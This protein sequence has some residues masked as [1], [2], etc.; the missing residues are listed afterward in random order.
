MATAVRFEG[1]EESAAAPCAW[2]TRESVEETVRKA[3]RAGVEA[4]YAAEDL[5]AGAAL[6]VR[7]HPLAAIGLAAAA[8]LCAGAASG[9]AAGWFVRARR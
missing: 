2:P 5:A 4:R 9:F 3:K 7:R 1:Q 6:K 8:G